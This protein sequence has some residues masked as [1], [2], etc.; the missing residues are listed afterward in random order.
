MSAITKSERCLS[1]PPH[2]TGMP[3]RATL[4]LTGAAPQPAPDRTSAPRAHTSPYR[5]LSSPYRPVPAPL[6]P[7]CPTRGTA[8]HRRTYPTAQPHLRENAR[9][10]RFLQPPTTKSRYRATAVP[11]PS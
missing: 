8:P 4:R 5:R 1:I 7:G 3:R 11:R 10:L 2:P 6:Q 9:R